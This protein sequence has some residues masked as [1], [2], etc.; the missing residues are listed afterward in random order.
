[1]K[2]LPEL[3]TLLIKGGACI[4]ANKHCPIRELGIHIIGT[5]KATHDSSKTFYFAF[6]CSQST[7]V[8]YMSMKEHMNLKYQLLSLPIISLTHYLAAKQILQDPDR[9]IWAL[10]TTVD[11]VGLLA[12]DLFS[13]SRSPSL[14]MAMLWIKFFHFTAKELIRSLAYPYE[15]S[16]EHLLRLCK[17]RYC[18]YCIIL[19]SDCYCTAFWFKVMNIVIFGGWIW[20]QRES[21]LGF[22]GLF[23]CNDHI[24]L[25]LCWAG[26]EEEKIKWDGP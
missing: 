7:T 14:Y 21:M 18:A 6:D 17:D 15:G 2:R 20:N 23:V 24:L 4:S 26:L 3:L 1:M 12:R 5:N 10:F 11:G 16:T 22:R 8:S 19:S 25:H 13:L 9:G